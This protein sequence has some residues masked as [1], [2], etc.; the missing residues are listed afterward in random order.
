MQD[1]CSC[2]KFSVY[3]V[4]T[5][6]DR[7]NTGPAIYARYLWESFK[8]DPDIAFHVVSPDVTTKH[9]RVH[10][11]RPATRRGPTFYDDVAEAAFAL[12]RDGDL[13]AMIHAN[14]TYSSSKLVGKSVPW[15]VQVND[16]EAADV[17][18]RPLDIVRR[19]GV[20]RFAALTWRHH[21]EGSLL[22]SVDRAVCNSAYVRD[23]VLGAYHGLEAGRFV[24]INKAVD[25][26]PFERPA[27]LPPDP[28]G[29]ARKGVRIF[30][31]GTDW[32]RKGVPDLI[33][34]VAIVAKAIPD[35]KLFIAGPDSAQD[36]AGINAV[37]EKFG[38]PG[39]V[40]ALGRIARDRLGP[41]F[42]HS[43]MF[44]LA[45]HAE[46]F[47]VAA[48]EAMAAGLPVICT[49]VGGLQEVVRDTVDGLLVPPGNPDAL[50]AAICKV[51]GDG[52]LRRRF[53]DN[54]AARARDFTV[55][56]MVEKIRRLYI[57]RA[58]AQFG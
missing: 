55:E 27:Q 39:R 36:I 9:A 53:G 15:I 4:T 5:V 23:R 25:R 58:G 57:E 14:A 37:S 31:V 19:H 11:I 7:A 10:Q 16:Y 29:A 42:W 8:D 20:R 21:R 30:T 52:A 6:F 46:A 32:R 1:L 28:F 12:A 49:N 54:G 44:A 51:A 50:A 2:H 41:Y 43:D 33:Q 35:L 38:V 18:R 24:V 48:V 17:L 26:I 47:G 3:F 40:K 34:A 13:P 45:S 56:C 22:R